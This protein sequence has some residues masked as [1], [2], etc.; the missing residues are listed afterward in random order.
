[1]TL[2]NQYHALLAALRPHHEEREAQAVARWVL[3]EEYDCSWTDILC[4]KQ[5]KTFDEKRWD[6]L[7]ECLTAGCPPQYALHRAEFMGRWF[8][9]D[10]GCLIPRPETALLVETAA[11]Q[12]DVRTVL[13]VG[14]GSG[15]IAITLKTLHPEWDVTA[16]DFSEKALEIARKNADEMGVFVKF[17]QCDV[18]QTDEAEFDLIVSNPPYVCEKEK[19]DMTASVLDFEPHSA[20]FVPDA[21]PLLFY[22]KLAGFHAPKLVV[23]INEKYAA[24]TSELFSSAGYETDIFLDEFGKERVLLGI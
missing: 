2:L 17:E 13:D 5:A 21:D 16:W 4:D 20:L 22:R 1:M 7:L 23:E 8:H 19:V 6:F 14:T 12:T 3:E 11:A 9:V 24:E 10:E 18:L 15:I